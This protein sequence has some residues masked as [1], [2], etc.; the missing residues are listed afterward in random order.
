LEKIKTLINKAKEGDSQAFGK[1]YDLFVDQIY[2][3]CL[4]KTGDTDV[5]QDI[6]SE[7]FLRV[8]R[9]LDRYKHKNFRAYLYT[10]A[11]NLIVDYY[12]RQAKT[13][14]LL[15]V[16]LIVDEKEDVE[17]KMIKKQEAKQLYKAMS[18]L[19]RNY[20]DVITLRFIEGL[21]V[22]ETAQILGRTG[23]SVRVIQHR[24]LKKLEILL[25]HEN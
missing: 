12:K 23:V 5:A 13:T 1:L 3:F 6:T 7:T 2:R 10:I 15:E 18:K 24:A 20:L 14:R 16:S 11:R 8:K 19:N 21:S 17:A 9:Y 4:I 25:N 22:K